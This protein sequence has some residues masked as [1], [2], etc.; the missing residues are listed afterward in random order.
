M[1][2][3]QKQQT[4]RNLQKHKNYIRF[5]KANYAKEICDMIPYY[6]KELVKIERKK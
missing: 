3:S 5:L 1:G 2:T 4:Q 6:I